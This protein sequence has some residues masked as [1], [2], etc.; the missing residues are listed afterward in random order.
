MESQNLTREQP[1]L[2]AGS[3]RSHVAFLGKARRTDGRSSRQASRGE[4]LFRRV[5]AVRHESAKFGGRRFRFRW[6]NSTVEAIYDFVFE[7]MLQGNPG[8]L[9][10]DE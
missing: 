6:R 3:T 2:R 9:S 7:N 8:S 10:T 5:C 1:T 4:N